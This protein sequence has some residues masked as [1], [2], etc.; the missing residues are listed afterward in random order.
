MAWISKLSRTVFGCE[1][2]WLM[3]SP[4]TNSTKLPV[5]ILE[6]IF[7]NAATQFCIQDRYYILTLARVSRKASTWVLPIFYE[8]LY[9][10]EHSFSRLITMFG[11]QRRFLSYVSLLKPLHLKYPTTSLIIT[12]VTPNELP[13]GLF[14]QW[15]PQLRRLA[16][17]PSLRME[18]KHTFWQIVAEVSNLEVV[19]FRLPFVALNWG[20][21]LVS[22]VG[23]F[24]F[25]RFQSTTHLAVNCV[26]LIHFLPFS[27]QQLEDVFPVLRFLYVQD[28]DKSPGWPDSPLKT[29]VGIPSLVKVLA[30]LSTDEHIPTKYQLLSMMHLGVHGD[31]VILS[32]EVSLFLWGTSCTEYPFDEDYFDI[33]DEI[34]RAMEGGAL[35]RRGIW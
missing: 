25:P 26:T 11:S 34:W 23:E 2:S 7:V 29:L 5:E 3:E 27:S 13:R 35:E 16:F 18:S 17:E 28:V 19:S 33:L 1:A 21:S 20:L 9:L 8:T 22:I 10:S 15:F 24:G 32:E 4:R 31:K 14:L 30:T 12:G 6:F